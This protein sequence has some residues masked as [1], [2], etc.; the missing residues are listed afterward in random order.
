VYK[1]LGNLFSQSSTGKRSKHDLK[2]SKEDL[3]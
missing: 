2:Y 1:G 3:S